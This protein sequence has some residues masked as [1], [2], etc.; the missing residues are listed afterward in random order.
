M[1]K[2][3]VQKG[4]IDCEMP[5]LKTMTYPQR[6]RDREQEVMERR[7]GQTLKFHTPKTSK[8]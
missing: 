6:V 7:D 4:K 1:T 2:V 8:K 3:P 5:T